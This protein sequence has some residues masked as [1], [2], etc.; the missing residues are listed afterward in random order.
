M[1]SDLNEILQ[2]DVNNLPKGNVITIADNNMDAN[3]LIHHFI[4]LFIR[5]KSKI[6]LLCLAQTFSHYS[7]VAHKLGIN[8]IK[9]CDEGQLTVIDG[10]QLSQEATTPIT[11]TL[12]TRILPLACIRNST[13]DLKSLL[14]HITKRLLESGCGDNPVT[15]IIDD[16][17]ILISLGLSVTT[18]VDFIHHCQVWFCGRNGCVV[19]LLHDDKNV[20]D[21]NNQQLHT[22]MIHKSSCSL[23]CQPLPSGYSRDVHGQNEDDDDD[24]DNDDYKMMML[25]TVV[26][27]MK[28][29]TLY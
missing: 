24:D 18:V 5:G 19:F 13:F 14:V 6:C 21:E 17:S 10:L 26:A 3:F 8:L 27:T 28:I 16:I 2:F 23:Q 15:L 25:T 7:S 11:Q 9:A 4:S 22:L 12:D 29:T 20:E 1:F